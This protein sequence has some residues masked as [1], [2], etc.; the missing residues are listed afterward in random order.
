MSSSD[1][2][3]SDEPRR[4]DVDPSRSA[5]A[6]FGPGQNDSRTQPDAADKQFADEDFIPKFS[7][8]RSK[9]EADEVNDW[10]HGA[11]GDGKFELPKPQLTPPPGIDMQE[12][13]FHK[14]VVEKPE[15]SR[16]GVTPYVPPVGRPVFGAGPT[17]ERVSQPEQLAHS[18]Q[19]TN[20][21]RP[22]VP[23]APV[24]ESDREMLSASIRNSLYWIV[25]E[26]KLVTHGAYLDYEPTDFDDDVPVDG[27]EF[28]IENLGIETVAELEHGSENGISS[29]SSSENSE[30]ADSGKL[31]QQSRA[32]SPGALATPSAD[33][34]YAPTVRVGNATVGGEAQSMVASETSADALRDSDS[35]EQNLEPKTNA[36]RQRVSSKLLMPKSE[37]SDPPDELRTTGSGKQKGISEA[38]AK[39]EKLKKTLISVGSVILLCVISLVV[40][41]DTI[42]AKRAPEPSEATTFDKPEGPLTPKVL[43]EESATSESTDSKKTVDS[44]DELKL[45]F[46]LEKKKDYLG[47]LDHFDVVLNDE[48]NQKNAKA[49]HGRGRVLTKLQRYERALED[50]QN[51]SEIDKTNEL[52]L[53][54]LAAVKYLLADYSGAARE[55]ERILSAH[56]DDVDALYGRGISYAALGKNDQ[57]IAD[58]EKV[59]KLKPGYDK[60]YRQMCTTYLAM[61]K[62]DQ[63][64]AAIS[65]AITACGADADLYFSRG[66]ARYQM[67]RKEEAVEDYNE[68]IKLDSKRKEYFNDRGY[69]LLELGRVD[70]A[71]TDF[72]Q[73]LEIDPHYKLAIDNLARMDKENRQRKK[74]SK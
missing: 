30:L 6:Q 17:P 37:V 15:V 45:A 25:Q 16:A 69:V 67:N 3:N 49:M 63:A 47:A 50:L 53:I 33:P 68:A 39:K 20:P 21:L 29:E 46:A 57:A 19:R 74:R 66:L 64:E 72:R 12:F 51:A 62:P 10:T 27:T 48:T 40:T 8:V 44:K 73:A 22:P 9:H 61:G 13:G 7:S 24:P 42:V 14:D 52:V 32:V 56:E 1:Q 36:S 11:G 18:E 26:P 43:K 60:A 4:D 41:Y 65:V 54:D 31:A 55:Y 70:E 5:A 58:F 71:K 23:I 35:S 28:W 34:D 38:D 59:V 2:T